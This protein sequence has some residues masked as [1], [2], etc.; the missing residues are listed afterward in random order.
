MGMKERGD[1]IDLGGYGGTIVE[2][3]DSIPDACLCSKHRGKPGFLVYWDYLPNDGKYR[4][5][6]DAGTATLAAADA[7]ENLRWV[8]QE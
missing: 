5:I 1:R 6:L 8:P 2:V 7:A 3:T 4:E